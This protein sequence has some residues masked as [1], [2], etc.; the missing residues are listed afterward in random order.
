MN[1]YLMKRTICETSYEHNGTLWD[2]GN[3]GTR[4]L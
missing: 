1:R 4:K 2:H 3:H